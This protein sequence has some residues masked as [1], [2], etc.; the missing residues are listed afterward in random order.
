M[1]GKVAASRE[2]DDKI[3]IPPIVAAGRLIVLTDD[4]QLVAFN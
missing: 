1:T 3:L 4:A 2:L